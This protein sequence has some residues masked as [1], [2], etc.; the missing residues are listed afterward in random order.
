MT[1][2]PTVIIALEVR[3]AE[4]AA[5][6]AEWMEQGY[7]V[8]PLVKDV[9]HW[10]AIGIFTANDLEDYF[11]AVNDRDYMIASEQAW[12]EQHEADMDAWYAEMAAAEAEEDRLLARYVDAPSPFDIVCNH[13]QAGWA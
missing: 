3:L 10:H 9:A 4:I 8:F 11:E 2:L 7:C 6:E 5:Q 13:F 1:Q 12:R